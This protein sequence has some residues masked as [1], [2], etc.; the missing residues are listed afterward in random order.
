[1]NIGIIGG[2]GE[3]GRVFAR[4]FKEDG[5]RVVITGRNVS[6]GERISRSL[7]VEFSRDNVKTAKEMD[8]VIVSCPIESTVDVIKE[9]APH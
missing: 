2:T 3:F 9:V 7:G 5:H 1:M 4:F 6:K 8:V